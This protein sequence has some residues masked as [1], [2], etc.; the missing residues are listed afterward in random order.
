MT[1]TAVI[2]LSG[3]VGGAKLALGLSQVLSA[4]ELTVITNT[5]DDFTY[6]D[7]PISPD[8]DTVMYTLAGMNNT[9]Q[10]WGLANE[11]WQFMAAL[12]N[13]GG[14]SWFQLGDKD[15]ATHIQRKALLTSGN[16]T[17][18]TTKLCKQLAIKHAILPMSNEPVSSH[19]QLAEKFDE[20]AAGSLM[21]FQEYFVKYQCQ[22]VIQ[23][24][25]FKGIEKTKITVQVKS[26]IDQA[27]ILIVCP[28]NP[29]VSIEPILSVTGMTD[30]LKTLAVR[31]V[32]SPII[33]GAAIKGP[34]A[35]M[36]AELNMPVTAV[37]VAE[38]YKNF[39]THF[40]IDHKDAEHA[41]KIEAMGLQVIVTNTLMT[42]DA[43]KRKLA[44]DILHAIKK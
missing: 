35:K 37:A 3:G 28:S 41:G 5:A 34:A 33:A 6:L 18:A 14:K 43:K 23:A 25:Q 20:Y 4:D 22:P 38:L 10:G 15:L 44:A 13:L 26:A 32:V 39:A 7:L 42:S 40:V 9:E 21:G 17:Q 24:Y 27:G 1:N 16:L 11:S 30:A 12:K 8:L 19:V 29:F 2:A 31:V 36:M